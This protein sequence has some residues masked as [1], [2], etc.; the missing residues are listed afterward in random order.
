M[1]YKLII[2]LKT[3]EEGS[4]ENAVKIAKIVKKLE[5]DAK[6]KDVEIILACQL[7]DIKEIVS[8]GVK[9]YSQHIDEYSFGANTGWVIAESLKMAG[10]SGTLI[11]HSEHI[12]SLDEIDKR[13]KKS[14][15][16]GIECCVCARTKKDASD[17]SKLNPDFIAVEPKELIGG[18]VSISSAKPEL[19]EE[20]VKAVKGLPLLVGAGVKNSTDVKKGI[21]LG[22]RGILVASGVVKAKDVEKAIKDLLS[23]F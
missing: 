13:I 4:S 23:G 2:N 1:K 5:N 9:T 22:A 16:A 3:Y 17:I 12:L 20:S 6:K 7:I 8:L 15:E 19:I 11:S 18:D 21:E 14:R 10:V